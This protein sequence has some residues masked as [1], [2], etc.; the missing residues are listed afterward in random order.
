MIHGYP[1]AIFCTA[2]TGLDEQE[3]TRFL[4]LSPETHNEK[5]RDT[6]HAKIQSESK[7]NTYYET[8]ENDPERILLMER[9]ELIKNAHIEDIRISNADEIEKRFL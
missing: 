4:L 6:I 8:I 7:D 5:F 2:S 1:V 3:A 9:I